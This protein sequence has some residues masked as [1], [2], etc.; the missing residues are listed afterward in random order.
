MRQFVKLGEIQGPKKRDGVALKKI[1]ERV[2]MYNVLNLKLTDI[3]KKLREEDY[4]HGS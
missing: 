2:K 4:A 3:L 1:I